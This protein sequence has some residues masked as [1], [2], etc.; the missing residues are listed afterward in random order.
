MAVLLTGN[1]VGIVVVIALPQ[2]DGPPPT[3][4]SSPHLLTSSSLPLLFFLLFHLSL[5]NLF[6]YLSPS[7]SSYN[8]RVIPSA[9]SHPFPL[10]PVPC[11]DL[12]LSENGPTCCMATAPTNPPQQQE[13][14][15]QI[16]SFSQPNLVQS[17]HS[18]YM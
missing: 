1:A 10:A 14:L 12:P 4:F 7:S 15:R 8:V 16:M 9:S 6:R 18:H 17:S 5:W 13:W 3:P 11:P 2:T